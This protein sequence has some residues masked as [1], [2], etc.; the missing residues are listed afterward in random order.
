VTPLVGDLAQLGTLWPLEDESA[1]PG[2]YAATLGGTGIRAE[3]T[4]S[5]RGALH[6]YTFPAGSRPRIAVDL[7]AGGIDFPGMRTLPTATDLALVSNNA[8]HGSMDM[9][10]VRV[11]V[12][13][14][15]DRATAGA[16]WIGPGRQPLGD[17]RTL[18]LAEMD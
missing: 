8:V 2:I 7:S 11:Y 1:S 5:L 6:R 16:L 17:T 4:T 3:L 9:A 13:V 10:G 12:Y 18:A 15:V 14:E